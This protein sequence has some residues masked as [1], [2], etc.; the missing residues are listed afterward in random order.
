[1][2]PGQQAHELVEVA[3]RFLHREHLALLTHQAQIGH[4]RHRVGHGDHAVGDL[5]PVPR[6]AGFAVVVVRRPDS[7]AGGRKMRVPQ[8]RDARS[9]VLEAASWGLSGLP[10]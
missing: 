10:Q 6:H 5:H 4:Q 8:G 3:R 9:Q 1:M 7:L 2:L